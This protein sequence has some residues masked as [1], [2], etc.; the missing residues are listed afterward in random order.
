MVKE[1]AH[2]SVGAIVN[3]PNPTPPTAVHYLMTVL[4]PQMGTRLNLRTHR[5]LKTICTAIDMV[6]AQAADVLSQQMKSLVK[7]TEDGH[8]NS[9]QFLELLSPEGSSL[10]E[11]AEE[12]YT[13]REYLLGIRI[14]NY[15]QP[16][17]HRPE[18]RGQPEKGGKK[19]REKGKGKGKES[20]KDNT[21]A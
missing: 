8:W 17:G 10:L 18:G 13:S 16:T 6:A 11:R 4:T 2:G 14:K 20:D 15:D 19:G 7:A 5:E 1:S 12:L 9:A 21:G 3:D